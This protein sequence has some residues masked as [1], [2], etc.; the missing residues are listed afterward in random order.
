MLLCSSGFD[1]IIVLFSEDKNAQFKQTS[2]LNLSARDLRGRTVIHHLMRTCDHG[3]YQNVELLKLFHKLGAPV[4]TQDNEGKTPLDYALDSGS[5]VMATELQR[6]QGKNKP[7][8]VSNW[9]YLVYFI[10]LY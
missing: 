7:Q 9:N 5:H 10:I 4:D 2:A 6:L 3:T 8:M 1:S